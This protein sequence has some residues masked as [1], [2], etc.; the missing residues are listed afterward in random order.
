MIWQLYGGFTPTTLP[1]IDSDSLRQH[2][3]TRNGEIIC[4]STEQTTNSYL[5]AFD[6][7]LPLCSPKILPL[8]SMSVFEIAQT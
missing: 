3:R 5:S 1:E 6:F 4:L 8:P 7:N 2:S